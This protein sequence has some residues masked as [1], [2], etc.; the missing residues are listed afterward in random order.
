MNEISNFIKRKKLQHVFS[1]KEDISGYPYQFLSMRLAVPTHPLE[2]WTNCFNVLH[3]CDTFSG[4]LIDIQRNVTDGNH[5]MIFVGDPEKFSYV[6]FMT[7]RPV[8]EIKKEDVA[9][10]VWKETV[11]GFLNSTVFTQSILFVPLKAECVLLD[12]YDLCFKKAEASKTEEEA[13]HFRIQFYFDLLENKLNANTY[14]DLYKY[15][16]V[17]NKYSVGTTIYAKTMGSIVELQ[18]ATLCKA[19]VID[20]TDP[21]NVMI[22][23]LFPARDVFKIK[24]VMETMPKL[25]SIVWIRN[26]GWCVDDM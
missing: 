23:D 7:K 14:K 8:F 24:K 17:G 15:M 13:S 18:L 16:A 22:S 25:H 3:I 11:I 26:H 5:S 21:T 10:D 12:I 9:T 1:I 20:K 4:K 6:K 19:I 2:D